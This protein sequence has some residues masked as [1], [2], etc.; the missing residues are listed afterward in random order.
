[1]L[2]LSTRSGSSFIRPQPRTLGGVLS[3]FSQRYSLTYTSTRP[4]SKPVGLPIQGVHSHGFAGRQDDRLPLTATNSKKVPKEKW[5]EE[6]LAPD[7]WEKGT[8]SRQSKQQWF[9]E[10]FRILKERMR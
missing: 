9:K 7:Y 5:V 1:M 2:C 3:A 6:K 8:Q 4:L 10:S